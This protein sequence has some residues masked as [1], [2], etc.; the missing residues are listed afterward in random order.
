MTNGFKKII[1]RPWVLISVILVLW[2]SFAAVTKLTLSGID[3]FQLQFFMFGIASII[4]TSWLILRGKFKKT[5]SIT[6]KELLIV[7]ICGIPFWLYN[8][9][10][11]LS[12]RLIPAVEASMLNYLFPIMIVVFAIPI[13]KEKLTFFGLLSIILGFAGAVIILTGGRINSFNL[14]NLVG[15]LLAVCA[16]I[17]WGLFS[18]LDRWNKLSEMT[19]TYFFVI[20]SFILSTISVVC[21][22]QFIIPGPLPLL[23]AL[24]I[25]L[26]NVVLSL[27]LWLKVLKI[28]PPSLV[29][30]CT[31]ITPF[32]SLLF[33]MVLT[34]EP[35]S[36]SQGI[37]L[38]IIIGAIAVQQLKVKPTNII[39]SKTD[40]Q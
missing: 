40:A 33:I 9:L 6:T 24:W 20:E 17:S 1:D 5:I 13:K 29:A 3:S 36:I 8:F 15:D 4:M 21:F 22:S 25:A 14:T 37:G 38:L 2:G 12:L 34:G 32:I 18:N 28:V 11:I 16:A 19:S 27:P 26:S 30:I 31:F 7:L 39:V 10:Y 23:G 35:I